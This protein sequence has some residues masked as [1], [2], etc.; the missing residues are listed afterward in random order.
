MKKLN[1]LILSVLLVTIFN[2]CKKDTPGNDPTPD[3]SNPSGEAMILPKKQMRAAWM[4]TA[5]GL[6]WPQDDYIPTSQ[7][8]QY[9]SY[10]EKFKQLKMNAVFVQVKGMGD[11]FYNSPYEPWSVAITG[12]RGKDPG[13]D[14]LKFM[15]EEAHARGIEF[16]AWLN[17]YRIATRT[18]ISSSY[19]ALH[20]SVKPEWV[21]SHEKIQIYN[22]ALPEVRQRL[23]DIVKDVITKYEVDGIHFDDYFYPDPTT[24]G[25]MVSDQNDYQTYK[26]GSETIEQF[27]RSNIDKAI[28][29]VRDIIIA[30]KPQVVFSVSPASDFTYN[31]NT[32][33]ADIKKWAS[34]GWMDVVI[35]QLYS[36]SNFANKIAE[37]DMFN[38]KPYLMIGHG[39]YVMNGSTELSS[40]FSLTKNK[41]AVV[42]TLLYSA[43]YLNQKP[44]VT[45]K[46]AELWNE[47]AVLPFLGRGV[48][49]APVAP[50][51]VQLEGNTLR[52][53]STGNSRSVVYFT[54][55]IKKEAKVVTITANNQV[56]ASQTGFYSITTLNADNKESEASKPIKK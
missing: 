34:E 28:K 9:I 11:A 7:K 4:A 45:N 20:S 22:P 17:P 50:Q 13:Y 35:P 41:K 16:H 23:A 49:P 39:Y 38:N 18:G 26:T 1:H 43:K 31:L 54:D 40:Q 52:W 8:E 32:M 36:N 6:D 3:P 56:N 44:D 55:D 29:G 48:A 47:P 2:A 24:A 46:L 33:Y 15:I 25:Q 53:T 14:V 37:W 42:G 30:T 5:W 51:N 21:I 12:T 19:P 27:R 10:L